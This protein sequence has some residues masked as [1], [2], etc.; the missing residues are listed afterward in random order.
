MPSFQKPESRVRVPI[1]LPPGARTLSGDVPVR[2]FVGNVVRS[3]CRQVAT[4]LVRAAGRGLGAAVEI[5]HASIE[6]VPSEL[7]AR[8]DQLAAGGDVAG[9]SAKLSRS[10][11]DIQAGVIQRLLSQSGLHREGVLAVGAHD[12]GVWHVGRDEPIGY[13]CLC[14]AARLAEQTGLCV[15]DAFPARDLAGGGLGGPVTALPQWLLLRDEARTRLLLDLG[16]TTRLTY[17][18]AANRPDSTQ[19]ILS[20]DAGPGTVLL[21][22]LATQFTDGQLTYDHG[23]QLAVQGRKIPQVIEHWLGDP[24]FAKPLPRWYAVGVQTGQELNTTVRMAIEAGWTVRDLLCTATHLIAECVKLAF[25]THL[26]QRPAMDEIIVTGGGSRNG[27]LLREIGQ[28]LPA[29]P[30]TRLGE[31]GLSGALLDAASVAVLAMLHVDQVPANHPAITGSS[32]PRVLG[33]LS[34]GST[35]A[36]RNLVEHIHGSVAAATLLRDAV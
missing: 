2:L 33:R 16:R 22:R 10:L 34:P 9:G 20:F 31:F 3:A 30:F 19:R 23:G 6:E 4:V 24:Y 27:M 13:T 8:F 32:S 35:L 18:P 5:L 28:R 12:P 14:D 15:I 29:L 1:R 11:A 7:C 21:D 26:P 25:D 17:L 36:W